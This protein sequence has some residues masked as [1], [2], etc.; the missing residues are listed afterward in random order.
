MDAARTVLVTGAT[1]GLGLET[2]RQLARDPA[3][4]V[5]GTGRNA[6]ATER[7]L[8]G[9]AVEPLA[10]DLG[11]QAS[12]AAV[13][14]ELA[15]RGPLGVL[16]ANAGIQLVQ[17]AVSADGWEL[18]FAVNHL[19]HLALIVRLLASGTLTRGSRIL[20]VASGTHDPAIRTGMPHA[21]LR[22][23]ADMARPAPDDEAPA[24][25]GRRRYTTS[26]LAN[27]M[28]TYELARRLE[29]AGITVNA[30]DP[31][32]MPGTGLARG[33]GV[34][35]R[36]AFATVMRALVVLP[37]VSSP[38]GS[39]AELARLAADPA[40][41]GRT[42]RYVSISRERRSSDASYDRGRQAAL[43]RESLE[44]LGLDDPTAS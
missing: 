14:D 42:G 20:I 34:V 33:A 16:V 17:P 9:T 22:S 35:A 7:A 2:A 11:S 28:T 32:L 19:G 6:A 21:R 24:T 15:A 36:A 3:L 31:G 8:A 23:A 1:S 44:L 10:L 13:A 12:V 27:V 30:F 29:P 18:T 41:D 39:G 37:G 4:T 38:R 25:A 40:L 26:K 43:W 5:V